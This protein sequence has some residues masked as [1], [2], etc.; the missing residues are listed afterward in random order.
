MTDG[1]VC[2]VCGTRR[3]YGVVLK[4]NAESTPHT[5]GQ[6]VRHRLRSGKVV[7]LGRGERIYE[8][9]ARRRLLSR[10]VSDG[11]VCCSCGTR[12]TTELHY[13]FFSQTSVR[14]HCV[15]VCGTRRGYEVIMLINAE[16]TPHTRPGCETRLRSSKFVRLGRGEKRRLKIKN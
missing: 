5:Q 12:R 1:F 7:R 6:A 13:R 10:R 16:S 9:I 2:W 11:F 4:I 14:W 3:S 8:I 15:L